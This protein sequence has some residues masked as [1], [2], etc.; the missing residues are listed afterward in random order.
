MW[1]GLTVPLDIQQV[2]SNVTMSMPSLFSLI[3]LLSSTHFFCYLLVSLF[4]LIS[5]YFLMWSAVCE[6]CLPLHFQSFRSIYISCFIHLSFLILPILHQSLYFLLNCAFR[7]SFLFH[8][9]CF[10]RSF[11]L[12]N[13][14]SPLVHLIPHFF[15][16]PLASF[17]IFSP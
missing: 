5:L 3:Q 11:L 15:S 13:L 8:L 12:L 16:A 2:C 17:R 7:P 6:F 4:W 1:E 14:S 9:L 10:I